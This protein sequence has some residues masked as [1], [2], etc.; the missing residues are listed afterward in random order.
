MALKDMMKPGNGGLVVE[1]KMCAVTEK[2]YHMT[3]A[4]KDDLEGVLATITNI[5]AFGTKM[6]HRN[7][8]FTGPPGTGKTLGAQYIATQLGIPFYDGKGISSPEQ[9]RQLFEYL[10][11][12]VRGEAEQQPETP[13]RPKGFFAKPAAST[14]PKTE[15]PKM[16]QPFDGKRYAILFLD[17]IDKFSKRDTG[18][19]DPAQQ[20]TLTQLLTEMD[21]TESNE[22]IFVFGATNR[23]NDIDNALRRGG[24][25][26]REISFMPPDK[27]GRLEIMK[28]HAHGKGG[29]KFKVEPAEVEYAA[30]VTY[31]YTGG[32]ILA[33]LNEAFMRTIRDPSRK[34]AG[35]NIRVERADVEYAL[36][37]T[38]PSAIRDMPF[39]EPSK[40]LKDLGGYDMHK[41]VWRRVLANSKG[42]LALHYGPKGTG[43]S[44][45]PEALAG[46]YGYNYMVV[47]GSEPED[48]FVGETGK[49]LDRYLERAK[50]LAPCFLVFDEID[51]LVEKKGVVSHKGDWTGRLQ[52]KLSRPLEG[53]YIIGTVNNPDEIRG[54]FVDRFPHKLY[55]GMPTEEQQRQIWQLYLPQT[56]D[57]A[58]L[59][60]INN[61]LSCRDIARA[62]QLITDYGLEPTLDVYRH[63]VASINHH[64]DEERNWD[65]VRDKTGD[66]VRDYERLQG[67]LAQTDSK[68]GEGQIKGEK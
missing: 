38:K 22:G 47:S 20:M 45:F 5:Q 61:G 14:P 6:G 35:G 48:K 67:F 21:G 62:A 58:E 54:A 7:F 18:L 27:K 19:L 59:V 43:K 16:E 26:S 53:V 36:K 49:E 23:P 17:E 11:G 41:E 42:T 33:L 25:F 30:D 31:G 1:P 28:I 64:D 12:Q 50:Q 37:H 40:K 32:D 8:L 63:L 34:D 15:Q 57:P 68:N 10:R 13:P 9:V 60:R 4:L 52:S 3:A 65:R 39:R 66:S 2:D 46:E 44:I 55:F 51:A 56:I 24:R 29:H